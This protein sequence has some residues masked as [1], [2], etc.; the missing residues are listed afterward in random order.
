MD[1]KQFSVADAAQALLNEAKQ[2]PLPVSAR[3]CTH[4]CLADQIP[5][6]VVLL[7]QILA[8]AAA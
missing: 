6:P 8:A 4:P 2:T 1:A 3:S 7:T 5:D